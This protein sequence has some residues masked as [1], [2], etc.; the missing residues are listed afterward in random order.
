ML[1]LENLDTMAH[2]VTA[3]G[4]PD[5]EHKSHD[6]IIFLHSRCHVDAQCDVGIN[7]NTL[8]VACAEC[9]NNICFIAIKKSK[10]IKRCH[11]NSAVEVSYEEEAGFIDIT[12]NECQ[13]LIASIEV[14]NKCLKP[15]SL[16]YYLMGRGL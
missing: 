16:N 10:P 15:K 11:I 7:K 3:N 13:K 9:N 5:C 1:Y 14:R 6:P 4:M 2:E 8:E 12:C